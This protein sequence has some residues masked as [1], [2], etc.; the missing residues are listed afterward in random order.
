MK[1]YLI[2]IVVAVLIT[3]GLTFIALR[4]PTPFPFPM[5]QANVNLERTISALNNKYNLKC[6]NNYGY[7]EN[8]TSFTFNE[9][10]YFLKIEENKVDAFLD[11]LCDIIVKEHKDC[12]YIA[13]S[14]RHKDPNEEYE[15]NLMKSMVLVKN[16]ASMRVIRIYLIKLQST[17]YRMI[18]LDQV[19]LSRTPKE[20]RLPIF[21][22]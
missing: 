19:Y 21:G 3:F 13:Y 7:C 1:K 11:D 15:V 2:T 17:E 16:K 8:N 20:I 10:R 9:L 12:G 14:D 5:F 18:I 6:E 22:K 4:F